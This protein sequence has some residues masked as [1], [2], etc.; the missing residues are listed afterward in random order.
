MLI[1]LLMFNPY[2]FG[3]RDIADT[4]QLI[5]LVFLTT[6]FIPAFSVAMMKLL[7]LIKSLSM[8]DKQD[9]T[10]PF[11]ATGIFYLWMYIN[12]AKNT[13][14]PDAYKI[15]VLGATIGLFLAF[16]I[17]I[18]SKISLHAVGMGGLLAMIVLTMRIVA[19]YDFTMF[20]PVLGLITITMNTL[21][22]IVIILAGLVCTSRLLLQA[23]HIQEIYSGFIVGFSTQFIATAILL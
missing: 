7:G 9:R 4:G 18:F 21:L 16:I 8:E 10:G 12:L 11:I 22:M 6:F 20:V 5:I 1:I 2:I 19:Y 13:N 17:N 3:Q 15:F 14:I 23:H